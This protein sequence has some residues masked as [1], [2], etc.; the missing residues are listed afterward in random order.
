MQVSARFRNLLRIVASKYG[1]VMHSE[2]SLTSKI[3]P[4]AK[5]VNGCQPLT[6]FT[7]KRNFGSL[8]SSEFGSVQI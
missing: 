7:K 8:M 2:P 1:A 6:V 4:F 3:E 5:M